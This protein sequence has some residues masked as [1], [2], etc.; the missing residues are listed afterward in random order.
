MND[1]IAIGL[2]VFLLAGNAFF[3]AAE[4]AIMSTRR[5]HRPRPRPA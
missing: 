1:W 3:V 5:A 4:F 2:L